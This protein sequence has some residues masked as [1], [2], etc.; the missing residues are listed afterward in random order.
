[1][2]DSAVRRWPVRRMPN[3]TSDPL[4]PY[5]LSKAI[6]CPRP[7][8]QVVV[9]LALLPQVQQLPGASQV[10][11]AENRTVADWGSSRY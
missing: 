8:D 5:A 10:V 9:V 6:G 11:K 2:W 4:K 3:V 1:M 7:L